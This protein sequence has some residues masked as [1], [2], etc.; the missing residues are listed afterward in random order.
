MPS[1]VNDLAKAEL[2]AMIDGIVERNF[3][4]S[5][6]LRTGS[7]WVQ[8]R[9]RFLGLATGKPASIWIQTPTAP[10]NDHPVELAPGQPFTLAFPFN[11]SYYR[12]VSAA[13]QPGTYRLAGG[14]DVR[15]Y[16]ITRPNALQKIERR[17]FFRCDIPVSQPIQTV[18]WPGM[19]GNK[20]TE[21]EENCRLR[22]GQLIN[23]SL[24]GM[25]LRCNTD[26]EIRALPD[27]NLAMELQLEP[28]GPLI[29][30]LATIRRA[31]ALN[32]RI[33]ELAV[34]FS[35][36]ETTAEGRK[37]LTYLSQ[38]LAHMERRNIRRKRQGITW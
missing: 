24:G 23:L 5:L 25:L 14:E 11:R 28:G 12:F 3:P 9:S 13:I 26:Q 37:Q 8:S 2:D 16:L 4:V 20:P 22:Q 1:R 21:S 38:T 18:F 35:G 10:P 27:T 29:R 7:V 17:N 6:E 36:L 19:P 34:C 15:G 33:A 32:D 30:T 31:T